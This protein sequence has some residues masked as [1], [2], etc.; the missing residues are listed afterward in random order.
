MTYNKLNKVL[1]KSDINYTKIRSWVHL[2]ETNN[3]VFE[4]WQDWEAI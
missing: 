4:S 1:P 2:R 3:L